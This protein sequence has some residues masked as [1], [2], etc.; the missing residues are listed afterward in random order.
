M[1]EGTCDRCGSSVVRFECF[2]GRNRVFTA[3]ELAN[4][5]VPE[6]ERWYLVTGRGVVH[7]GLIT[8]PS[9]LP[10]L[11]LHVCRRARIGVGSSAQPEAGRFDVSAEIA[12]RDSEPRTQ[13]VKLAIPGRVFSYRYP[14]SWAHIVEGVESRGL[15]G[16]KVL[17]PD[18]MSPR[19]LVRLE[20]MR[21]CPRCRAR[22]RRHEAARADG[23]S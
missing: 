15:C 20:G 9:D 17:D 14:S 2:D 10:Y 12:L 23:E 3:I 22:N 5:D 21:V 19:E 6:T 4:E 8:A 13:D 11:T 1:F 18:A 7:G 16:D